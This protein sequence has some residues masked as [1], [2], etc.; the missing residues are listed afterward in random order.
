MKPWKHDPNKPILD[1]IRNA[2]LAV[3]RESALHLINQ[4]LA[5]DGEPNARAIRR[6]LDLSARQLKKVYRQIKTK[7]VQTKKTHQ[8]PTH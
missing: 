7:W 5:Q 6:K 4:G 1:Q 2:P 3:K 8:T